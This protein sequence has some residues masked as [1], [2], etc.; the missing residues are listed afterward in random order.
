M[1][2]YILALLAVT[3]FI[4]NADARVSLLKYYNYQNDAATQSSFDKG[5]DKSTDLIRGYVLK[6]HGTTQI[7]RFYGNI[8]YV[9]GESEKA[10]SYRDIGNDAMASLLV[11]LY[12]SAGPNFN[13]GGT[14]SLEN[15]FTN[16]KD[17]IQIISDMFY[18]A[19]KARGLFL[20]NSDEISTRV[21]STKKL[22]K[23][24]KE[25]EK[26]NKW[27]P[28][29]DGI[30]EILSDLLEVGNKHPNLIST[31]VVEEEKNIVKKQKATGNG[32]FADHLERPLAIA[33]RAKTRIEQDL[34]NQVLKGDEV[35]KFWNGSEP[36][37]RTKLERIAR[38]IIGSVILE[39]LNERDL[40]KGKSDLDACRDDMSTYR[41]DLDTYKK[42]LK[43]N[44]GLADYKI[45]LD[46]YKHKIDDY[47]EEPST[48]ED[49]NTCKRKL[50]KLRDNLSSDEKKLEVYEKLNTYEN[51]LD[52]YRNKQ[53][54]YL[55]M[56]DRGVN[57]HPYPLGY[58]N[59]IICMYA[60]DVLNSDE[61]GLLAERLGEH[62]K[63]LQKD[64]PIEPCDKSLTKKAAS[65]Y[66]VGIF[67]FVWGT[68]AHGMVRYTG[69]ESG[70]EI[71]KPF[72]D[73]AETALRLFFAAL[74]AKSENGEIKLDE[75]RI[76]EGDLK[77]FFKGKDLLE[78]CV[79]GHSDTREEW[80]R[81]ISGKKAYDAGVLFVHPK[82]KEPK[83]LACELR[84][85]IGNFIWTFC[86]LMKDYP[87]II[88]KEFGISDIS[89]Y[90]APG[91]MEEK[92]LRK[93]AAAKRIDSI[94]NTVEKCDVEKTK[95]VI[96]NK[97]IENL[98]QFLEQGKELSD[99]I[100]RADKVIEKITE[101]GIGRTSRL[102]LSSKLKE[103]IREAQQN[104]TEALKKAIVNK[105]DDALNS[106][107]KNTSLVSLKR[108]VIGN[109]VDTLSQAT[110]VYNDLVGIRD[111]VKLEVVE[112]RVLYCNS[113]NFDA[114]IDG[115]RIQNAAN[116]NEYFNLVT[117]NHAEL[118]GSKIL[119]R[120]QKESVDVVNDP[121]S[122]LHN[123]QTLYNMEFGAYGE[124][125]P[126]LDY[127][128]QIM[129]DRVFV[130][131]GNSEIPGEILCNSSF[132]TYIGG[133]CKLLLTRNFSFSNGWRSSAD[134]KT[135]KRNYSLL[136]NK[137]VESADENSFDER[138]EKIINEAYISIDSS[139]LPLDLDILRNNLKRF[140]AMLTGKYTVTVENGSAESDATANKND[141]DK[142]Y[143]K[144]VKNVIKFID[145]FEFTDNDTDIVDGVKGIV[146]VIKK[147]IDERG[148]TQDF[149]LDMKKKAK[150][151]S[152]KVK[153]LSEV[154]KFKVEE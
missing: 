127:Y 42:D 62:K 145:L 112:K 21:E 152:E 115:M 63:A 124:S 87:R 28:D 54:A 93:I 86:W 150:G 138:L 107:L 59:D 102:K 61:I 18:I 142:Q 132:E 49:F 44:E 141:I 76:P 94:V 69:K 99:F 85:T 119:D 37:T 77:N 108:I 80:V 35:F 50:D 79:D 117:S 9:R 134:E 51:K 153:I 38:A 114:Q 25:L 4:S 3:S 130:T 23:I 65:N 139:V 32:I 135:V 131:H 40:E 64:F 88:E 125:Y 120:T 26:I 154:C 136:V 53:N 111:D 123:T 126:L 122:G 33:K 6:L 22:S 27:N 13:S 31:Q 67:P 1:K 104:E 72:P 109:L 12:P 20:K 82:G 45:E 103:A 66:E 129:D 98:D 55:K 95:Q 90:V 48:D 56:H 137:L 78:F 36:K 5:F 92:D 89:T 144:T 113:D 146:S 8:E 71:K 11:A 133:I 60:W 7:Q 2:R 29:Y 43:E 100:Y 17:L 10:C 14:G 39:R 41:R 106:A 47:T 96:I 57:V 16:Q 151:T 81:I 70:V 148:L 58:T 73:C 68:I 116:N 83:D 140:E 74:F 46:A 75:S 97:V 19:N 30:M 121:T 52:A 84:G 105:L 15:F 24:I 34:F 147:E 143:I 101:E 118:T 110:K 91:N 149:P 128:M